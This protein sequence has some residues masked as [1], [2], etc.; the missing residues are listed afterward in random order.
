MTFSIFIH[1]TFFPGIT[2]GYHRLW[3]HRCYNASLPLQ[4][5]LALAGAG[6]VEGS[7]KW[8]SRDHRAHH[9]YTDTEL[10]PYN[11]HRGLYWSHVGWIMT[12]PRTRPGIADVSDL[13]KNDVVRWQHENFPACLLLMGFVVPSIIPWLAW[14]DLSG[15]IVYAAVLRLVF[16][17]HVRIASID[18]DGHG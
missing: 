16:V 10:D 2:A 6:A 7:I 12:K 11:A 5:F 15:G 3:A 9:R 18:S 8:W 4:Y 14:G 17:H 1:R 13:K